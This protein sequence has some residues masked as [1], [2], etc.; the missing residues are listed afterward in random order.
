VADEPAQLLIAWGAQAVVEVWDYPSE[1]WIEGL[2]NVPCVLDVYTERLD[3]WLELEEKCTRPSLPSHLLFGRGMLTA[4]VMQWPPSIC[5][6]C[7]SPQP[8]PGH[9]YTL[10]RRL[11]QSPHAN[12]AHALASLS[13]TAWLR[14]DRARKRTEKACSCTR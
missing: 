13:T 7:L 6:P 12:A 9:W 1:R 11:G 10:S 5:E 2:P 8:T 4:A 3:R 14:W